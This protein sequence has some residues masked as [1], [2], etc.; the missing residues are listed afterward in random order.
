MFFDNELFFSGHTGIP[1]LYFLICRS[2]SWGRYLYLACSIAM[3]VC[4]LLTHN[5]YAIDV[6]G[7]YFMTYSIHALS[8]RLL[9]RLDS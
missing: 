9:H 1:F 6:L 4:V 3:G 2:P 8:R 7:A 5:H